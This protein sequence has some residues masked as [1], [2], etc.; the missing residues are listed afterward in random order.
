MSGW[1]DIKNAPKNKKLHLGW[2]ENSY[3]T[4]P[5]I[6]RE[7]VG[8]AIRSKFLIFNFRHRNATHYKELPSPP[9]KEQ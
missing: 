7:D 1:I 8:V 5:L 2:W 3:T 4:N 9:K 6:W